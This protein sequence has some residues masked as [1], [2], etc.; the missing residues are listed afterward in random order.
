MKSWVLLGVAVCVLAG[1]SSAT[2]T[3]PP[4]SE[5]SAST[6]AAPTSAPTSAPSSAPAPTASAVA[7]T[8]DPAPEALSAFRCEPAKKDRWEAAGFLANTSKK[9]VT[10]QV[11]VHVGPIDGSSRRVRTQQVAGVRSKGSSRFVIEDIPADG[12]TCHVQVLRTDAG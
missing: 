10:Y 6:A 12:D 7:A 2:E 5:P 3:G 8:G 9:A 1:C 4:A 11:T